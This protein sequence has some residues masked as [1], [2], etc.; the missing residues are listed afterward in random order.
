M[1]QVMPAFTL[2]HAG[3]NVHIPT[4]PAFQ[5]L[6]LEILYFTMSS[7]ALHLLYLPIIKKSNFSHS[8]SV[9]KYDFYKFFP[10][11]WKLN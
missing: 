11:V 5:D 10:N 1:D 2:S 9:A 8:F 4:K 3:V 6:Y 7:A